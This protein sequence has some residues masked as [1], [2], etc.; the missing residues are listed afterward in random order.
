FLDLDRDGQ[1]GPGEPA[2]AGV[3][4][5]NGRDVVA[6]DSDGRFALEM[7]AGDTVFAIKPP[8]H[9]VRTRDNGLPGF[10][11]HHFPDGSPGLRHGGMPA[12]TVERFEVA[13]QPASAPAGPLEV[14]VLA[15]PQVK[16]QA[17]VD[18]YAGDI[19]ADIAARP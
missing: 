6:S 4:I 15:D 11:L 7:R 9:A 19:I 2:A 3:K 16:N 5:S 17:D 10:W 13:L 1:R 14:L 18:Y 8:G 12:N